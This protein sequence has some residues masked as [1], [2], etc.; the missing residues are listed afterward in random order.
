MIHHHSAIIL[1][2]FDEPMATPVSF[3]MMIMAGGHRVPPWFHRSIHG[4]GPQPVCEVWDADGA[5]P[6]RP[7]V[8]R[9]QLHGTR[10][11]A[12]RQGCS[13]T[14][15][16]MVGIPNVNPK[17][18]MLWRFRHVSDRVIWVGLQKGQVQS[19]KLYS[20]TIILSRR[21]WKSQNHWP[22]QHGYY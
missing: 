18:W 22:K 3:P 9:L 20:E 8:L 2:I 5:V 12:S 11:L 13:L 15:M 16:S 10:D 14:K 21:A 6:D 17:Y 4:R 1:N 19:T 7:D